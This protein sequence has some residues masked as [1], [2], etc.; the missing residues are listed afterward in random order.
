MWFA[1]SVYSPR[2]EH[3]VAVFDV[4]TERKQAEEQIKKLNENLMAQVEQVEVANREL[5]RA[6]T[7]LTRSN[8]ELQE[9]AYVASHDLQEPLRMVTS[10]LQLLERRYQGQLD[11]DADEFIHFAVDGAQRMYELIRGLLAYSRVGTHGGPFVPVDCE[12]IVGQVLDNLQ[13][14][15]G[16]NQATVTY[17]PLPTV[18]ADPTQ[19]AQLFQNLIGNALKFRGQRP[20]EIH[21][22]AEW[23]GDEWLFR[24]CDNGIGIEIQYAERIFVIFQRLHTREEYPGTGIGLALCKRIV[25]R[26]GGRIWVESEPG[27]GS[28]FFFTLPDGE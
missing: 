28:C 5:N 16:E 6:L 26:H 1:I 14:V 27:Q 19:M 18:R 25:E 10:Y 13:I 21:V 22:G 12:E 17:D 20:P 4:I 11:A 9:F 7:E 23:Q 15:I 3:F 2:W 8:Q 24:V